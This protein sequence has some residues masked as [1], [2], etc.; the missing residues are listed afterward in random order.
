MKSLKYR[1]TF[2]LL[3]TII[4]IFSIPTVKIA[5]ASSNDGLFDEDEKIE[6]V[7]HTPFDNTKDTIDVSPNSASGII[8]F[9]GGM[10]V[11]WVVDGAITY[12]S[13]RAPSE[14]VALGLGTIEGRIRSMSRRGFRSINVSTNGHVSGCITFPCML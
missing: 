8:I 7:Q 2:L 11:G 5:Q 14:W 4:Q 13:G 3:I 9:F 10:A 12:Y 6:V 1:S